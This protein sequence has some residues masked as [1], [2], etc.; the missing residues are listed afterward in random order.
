MA[1]HSYRYLVPSRADDNVVA[2]STSGGV[3]VARS[4]DHP[5]FFTGFLTRPD[6]SAVALRTVA[7]IAATSFVDRTRPPTLDPVVTA[8]ADRLRFESF[9]G[10]G[11]VQARFDLLPEGYDGD[12]LDRGTTNVDV[13]EPLR[14]FLTGVRRDHT[15]LVRVGDAGLAVVSP[16]ETHV[17]RRVSLSS[18]W[19]RG[20]AEVQVIASSFEPRSEVPGA[21][22]AGFLQ[23]LPRQ[24]S[25]WIVPAGR[26]WRLASRPEPGAVFI[27]GPERFAVLLPV[28]RYATRVVLHGP[29]VVSGASAAS[30]WQVDLP[31]GRLLLSVSP[32][33]YRGFSGEGAVLDHLLADQVRE[34]ADLIHALLAFEPRLDLDDLAGKSGFSSSRVRS[35][36]TG[37]ATAGQVGYDVAEATYFHRELP[38]DPAAIEVLNPR[39]RDARGLVSAGAVTRIV[40][41]GESVAEV[42]SGDRVYRVRRRPDASYACTCQWWTSHQ[43][44]RGPCKHVLAAKLSEKEPE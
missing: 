32:D 39:L 2:L 17:E 35:A 3:A 8:H 5:A 33:P 30:T 18:R 15:I 40:H 21:V 41:A 6:V 7:S 16:D 24:G 31:G 37:L 12:I 42:T 26:S 27:S 22:A 36:L 4:G 1:E 23:R 9:S 29:V 43:G 44:S 13:N 25:G 38:Y 19:L 10:C 34:D 20:F 11:G 28:M 14:R